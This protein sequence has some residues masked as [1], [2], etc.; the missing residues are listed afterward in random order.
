MRC[1]ND[2]IVL[3]IIIII[4]RGDSKIYDMLVN[5]KQ[6]LGIRHFFTSNPGSMSD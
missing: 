3:K 6:F 1:V 2:I 4:S 5:S